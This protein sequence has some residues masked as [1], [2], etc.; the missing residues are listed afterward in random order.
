ML[1]P[2]IELFFI[3]GNINSQNYCNLLRNQVIPVIQDIAGKAFHNIWFQQDGALAHFSLE[4]WNLLN[5]V[6]TDWWIGRRGTTDWL[7]WSPDLN[8][9]FYWAYLKTKVYDTR[10]ANLE[11]LR[12]KIMNVSNSITPDFINDVIDTFHVRLG[13][14]QVGGHQFE[15]LIK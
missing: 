6:F 5:D 12:E 1:N 7:Q 10:S 15:H 3:E 8:S 2:I 13:H 9:F 4:A 14:C 11:E